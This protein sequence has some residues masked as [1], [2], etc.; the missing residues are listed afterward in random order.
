MWYV[1]PDS[2]WASATRPL[3]Y[4]C[5]S[6]AGVSSASKI[7]C[8]DAVRWWP[9]QDSEARDSGGHA[10]V[11]VVGAHYRSVALSK[12]DLLL[13]VVKV[14]MHLLSLHSYCA[15]GAQMALVL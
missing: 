6:T 9:D 11:V 15:G 3:R 4:L 14:R 10:V 13:H 12:E 8:L 7:A 1:C 5:F 2:V